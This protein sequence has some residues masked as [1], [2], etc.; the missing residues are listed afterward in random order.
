MIPISHFI[1]K[2]PRKTFATID[3]QASHLELMDCNSEAK[4]HRIVYNSSKYF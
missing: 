1:K 4:C 3:K 2:K